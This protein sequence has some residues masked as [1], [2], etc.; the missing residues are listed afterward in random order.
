MA[1]NRFLA[2]IGLL[3]TCAIAFFYDHNTHSRH[4]R[5]CVSRTLEAM[6]GSQEL[7]EDSCVT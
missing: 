7:Q 5:Y 3:T 2:E 6:D 4:R 1:G